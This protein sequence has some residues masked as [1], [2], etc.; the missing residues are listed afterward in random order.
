MKREKILY[1]VF[2]GLLC[3]WMVF[4]GVM[5]TFFPGQVEEI[6]VRFELPLTMIIPLGIAKLL[7]VIA[8]LTKLS[9]FLKLLAYLGLLI[10]FLAAFGNHMNA[11]DGQWPGPVIAMLLLMVSF[12]YDRRLFKD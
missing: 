5:F 4:Q 11:G 1:W 8:I 9:S 7:A 6:F 12:I 2:T 3:L 10:D